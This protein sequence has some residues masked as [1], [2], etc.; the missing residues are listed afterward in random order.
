MEMAS[1]GFL[2]GVITSIIMIGVGVL[3]ADGR[4]ITRQHDVDSDISIY[5]PVRNRDRSCYKRSHQ[6]SSEEMIF[7]L[8]NVK[9]LTHGWERDIMEGTI[10][11]IRKGDASESECDN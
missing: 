6:Y 4:H 1:I 7:V 10:D 8:N 2:L 5:V 9:R 11:Y 3:I